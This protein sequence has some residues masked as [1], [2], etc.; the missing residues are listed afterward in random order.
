MRNVIVAACIAVLSSL[1][2]V[3]APQAAT[4][5]A[6]STVNVRSGPGT[7][8][9]LLGNLVGGQVVN[10]IRCQDNWC[11]IDSVGPDGWVSAEYLASAGDV[12]S[13][14]P[15][16]GPS[17]NSII[18]QSA[19]TT[20]TDLAGPQYALVNVTQS[21]IT[22]LAEQRQAE[23]L[24]GL[25]AGT[26]NEP[27][28]SRIHPG[29]QLQLTI[30][31]GAD[32]GLFFGSG[33][34][35]SAANFVTFP[36]QA[37]DENGLLFIPFAGE[38]HAEDLSVRELEELIA[39][40]L[41]SRAIE[42]QVVVTLVTQNSNF[43]TVLGSVASP[44]RYA[45]GQFGDRV[46]DA[47]AAA[48]GLS[49]PD[50]QGYVTLTRDGTQHRI[51]FSDLASDPSENIYLR[52]GDLL[53]VGSERPSFIAM[54]A[55]N[56]T[57]ESDFGSQSLFL[58]EAI[59]RVGGLQS[60]LADPGQVFVFRNETRAALASISGELDEETFPADVEGIT[61]A[62]RVDFSS[63]ASLILANRFEMK[64]GDVLYVGVS[65]SAVRN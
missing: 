11:L 59:A 54:G 22:K 42:P 32:G 55:V 12:S 4:T 29:D 14:P 9:S 63:P 21:V 17:G 28:I 15:G 45:L 39:R 18:A 48:G 3:S 40:R 1:V 65:A 49:V 34:G 47:I 41:E 52:P 53:Y 58:S 57:G 7:N 33:N 37:I 44:Q 6:L 36:A 5:T 38:V 25:A 62:Y 30:F 24:P 56:L 20:P 13:L 16:I 23:K 51:K 26:V 64:D 27:Y 50:F 61:V 35:T 8:Y 2:A 43:A 46:L 10:V 31:E 60:N 19:I